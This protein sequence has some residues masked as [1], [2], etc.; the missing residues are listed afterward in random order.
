[1]NRPT[2]TSNAAPATPEKRKA[3]AQ[4]TWSSVWGAELAELDA[5]R[6]Q[7]KK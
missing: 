2:E 6:Q 4:A 7:E 1:M 3:R 5:A